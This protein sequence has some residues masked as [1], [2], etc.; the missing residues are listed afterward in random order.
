[1]LRPLFKKVRLLIKEEPLF[2]PNFRLVPRSFR[3]PFL[4]SRCL[5]GLLV[6]DFSAV[7]GRYAAASAP[8]YV[9]HD[10]DQS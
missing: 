5:V 10:Q 6:W 9:A 7:W 1:M 4:I 3:V 2:L 8:V